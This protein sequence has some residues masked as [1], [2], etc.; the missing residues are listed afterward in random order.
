MVVAV[1]RQGWEVVV[2]YT[3]I[4][5]ARSRHWN[6]VYD[7]KG[8]KQVSWFQPDPTVSLE[9]IDG[10]RLDRTEPVIDIGGGA[11]TLVDRLLERG[12]TDVTVLDV[13]AHALGLAQR[14]LS[15]RAQQVHWET[16]DLLQWTAPRRFALWHDRAVFHFL[17]DP[18]DRAH[19]R[20]LATTSVI[21]GGYL[22]LAT[23]AAD[24]P[25]Q[26]S[27]LAVA[28]YRADE[29]ADTLG[30]GFTTVK[31]RREHHHTPTGAAQPFTWLLMRHTST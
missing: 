8:A 25:E 6:E 12:H 5:S 9:L 23:F 22:I 19:Y 15:D 28:R 2:V 16:A 7:T 10:L 17:T 27:G 3:P 21:P 20:E 11:S 30:A 4:H 26:C 24:G 14:R 18:D 1:Q 29:L 31:T 13:S